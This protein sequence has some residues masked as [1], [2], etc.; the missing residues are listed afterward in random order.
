MPRKGAITTQAD[1]ARALRAVRDAGV[2]AQVEI[3]PDGTIVIV[4]VA[5]GQPPPAAPAPEPTRNI[6]L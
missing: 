5:E 4:P 1:V 6:V 2:T 3:R